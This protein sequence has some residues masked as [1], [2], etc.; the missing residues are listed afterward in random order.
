MLLVCIAAAE[1]RAH[2]VAAALGW[3]RADGGSSLG[4][5]DHREGWWV[6]GLRPEEQRCPLGVGGE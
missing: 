4:Q 5:G 3:A 6:Q 1:A 2:S